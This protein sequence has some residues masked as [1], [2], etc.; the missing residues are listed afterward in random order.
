MVSVMDL[1]LFARIRRRKV[2]EWALAYV[3][4]A[5]AILQII[6]VLADPWGVPPWMIKSVQV[7]VAMGLF[8]A[9]VLAWYHGEKGR[10]RVS[11]PELLLIAGL[12]VV[13]GLLMR[14]TVGNDGTGGGPSAELSAGPEVDRTR[15]FRRRIAVLPLDNFTGDPEQEHVVQG[16]HE[17]ITFRLGRIRSLDVISQTSVVGYRGTDRT[18]KEIGQEL[19][20]GSILEG[21][22]TAQGDSVR[23]ILRLV[24]TARDVREW[25]GQFG[26]DLSDLLRLQDQVA[27]EVTRELRAHLTPREDSLLA[28]SPR[29]DP[30]A[31]E[32]YLRARALQDG[33]EIIRLLNEAIRIDPTFAAPYGEL[34]RMYAGQAFAGGSDSVPPDE[35]YDR[36]VRLANHGLRLDSALASAWT[37]LAEVR[38]HRDR[39]YD[40]GIRL[41]EKALDINPS[42]GVAYIR[43]SSHQAAVGRWD[44]AVAAAREAQR[45]DPRSPLSWW[46]LAHNLRSS[47]R[48]REALAEADEALQLDSTVSRSRSVHGAILTHLGRFDEGI[49]ELRQAHDSV[50]L[51]LGLLRA[52]RRDE[53]LAIRDALTAPGRPRGI[54]AFDLARFCALAGESEEAVGYLEQADQE[55]AGNLMWLSVEPDLEELR[56]DARVQ[57][58]LQRM[59][60]PERAG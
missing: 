19:G 24:D 31:G 34:A 26:G 36:V 59:R 45:V 30:R 29:I 8:L 50:P 43:I 12:L 13:A 38:Y 4:A 51:A 42:Y 60:F 49:A 39:D 28:I 55:R 37:A 22:V 23:I 16:L 58:L 32:A 27:R 9:L 3:A 18:A 35:L 48:F 1:G 47:G 57:A 2:V 56:R 15:D 7:L 17:A 46:G 41:F 10:Q 25:T 54:S 11:G 44:E 20:V 5:W 33:R 21:S 52:G 6:D 53:A 14:L 40:G